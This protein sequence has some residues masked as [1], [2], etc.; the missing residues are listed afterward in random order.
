[1]TLS[2]LVQLFSLHWWVHVIFLNQLNW[3]FTANKFLKDSIIKFKDKKKE[4]VTKNDLDSTTP[5]FKYFISFL[6]L[7]YCERA[8]FTIANKNYNIVTINIYYITVIYHNFKNINNYKN[9]QNTDINILR[10]IC[11]N[12]NNRKQLLNLNWN[13]NFD[14]PFRSR[15]GPISPLCFGMFSKNSFEYK[16]FSTQ[17][18]KPW[19][20]NFNFK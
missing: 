3:I 14:F 20:I 4:I 17:M 1:M 10:I 7:T 13:L 12:R 8:K 9:I 6:L 16:L 18:E 2:P 19:I 5:N 11:S 15:R